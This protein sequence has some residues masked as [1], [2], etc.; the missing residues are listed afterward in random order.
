MHVS[1]ARVEDASSWAMEPDR[2][3]SELLGSALVSGIV[4]SLG[5]PVRS[6]LIPVD[7]KFVGSEPGIR[8]FFV[9][10]SVS[11]LMMTPIMFV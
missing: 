9:Q 1:T 3:G 6:S 10:L 5:S 4:T 11:G 8:S 7:L 2:T